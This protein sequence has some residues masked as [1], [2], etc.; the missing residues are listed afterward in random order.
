MNFDT[1]EEILMSI[2]VSN[3]EKLDSIVSTINEIKK[4]NIDYCYLYFTLLI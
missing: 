2:E 1:M 3:K 4:S